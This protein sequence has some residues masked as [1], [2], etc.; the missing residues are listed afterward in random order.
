MRIIFGIVAVAALSVRVAGA[1]SCAEFTTLR[2]TVETTC[3]CAAQ[4]SAGAY[5]QCVKAKLKADGVKGP[6]KKLMT[7]TAARSI[8]GKAGVVV[9]CTPGKKGKV[10]KTTKCTKGTACTSTA[11]S[12]FSLFPLSGAD[13]SAAGACPT[14]TTTS[15]TL[16]TT[17]TAGETTTTT[18]TIPTL[19]VGDGPNGMPDAGE[20][21][22]DGNLNPT[23]GCTVACT[24]CGNMTVTPPEACD[25]GNLVSGDGCDANCQPTGC[26]NGLAVSPE[27]CDDG[28]TSNDDSCP[29]DCIVD[30]C[31]PVAATDVPVSV[32]VGGNAD[33]GAVTVLVDYPEGK[34]SIPG[35]GGAIPAGILTDYPDGSTPGPNDYDHAL[36]NF[37]LGQLGTPVSGL[38][39]KVHFESCQSASVPVAGDFTCTVI[40]ASD[41]SGTPIA[42][43]VTCA[44]TV[45]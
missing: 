7:T 19:C 22:D 9:C 25:D 14:T 4:A 29:S 44:V 30:P 32:T 23:D 31:V 41:T 26:G 11:G 34:V 39:F 45:P 38:L 8:C 21:C 42:S 16:V 5:K 18:T 6:C 36:R 3:P 1:A 27:T 12:E 10:V 28:N 13:C 17:T 40:D 20:Q 43:G 24:I 37:V 33:I 35:S 2:Q 15:T